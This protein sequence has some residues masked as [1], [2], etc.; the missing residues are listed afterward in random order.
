MWPHHKSP[1]EEGKREE[2]PGIFRGKK[3]VLNPDLKTN[4][5]F[6]PF[7]SVEMEFPCLHRLCLPGSVYLFLGRHQA[8]FNPPA[9]AG[10]IHTRFLQP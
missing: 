5:K 9:A 10:V 2:I 6:S 1:L 8:H 3:S 7:S 4:F